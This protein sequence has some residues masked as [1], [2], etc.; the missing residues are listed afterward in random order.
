[1]EAKL[2]RLAVVFYWIKSMVMTK[3]KLL[4]LVVQMCTFGCI[5]GQSASPNGSNQSGFDEKSSNPGS[6]GGATIRVVESDGAVNGASNSQSFKTTEEYEV[7][8]GLRP[9][10]NSPLHFPDGASTFLKS[11]GKEISASDLMRLD[12]K[13][14]NEMLYNLDAYNV[15]QGIVRKEDFDRLP[16]SSKDIM[17]HHTEIFTIQ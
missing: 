12:L 13:I 2:P 10:A 15:T 1:M 17:V 5:W 14:I 11:A 4:V 7:A 3:I 6:N 8:A 9:G 16:Q